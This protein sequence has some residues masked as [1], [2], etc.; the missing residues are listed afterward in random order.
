MSS[1][2]LS[3]KTTNTVSGSFSFKQVFKKEPIAWFALLITLIVGVLNGAWF[4]KL[5][6]GH[7]VAEIYTAR[8]TFGRCMDM[9]IVIVNNMDK[10]ALEIR[11]P[12]KVDPLAEQGAVV[13]FY[14][15]LKDLMVEPSEKTLAPRKTTFYV[16]YR[17]D[18]KE[19]VLRIPKLAPGE[20]IHLRYAES[21]KDDDLA[22]TRNDLVESKYDGFMDKPLVGPISYKDGCAKIKR[23]VKDNCAHK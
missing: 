23:I 4:W 15:T 3:K 12:I 19:F 10:P 13:P 18:P 22:K 5:F 17:F 8:D 21:A 2:K 1:K 9:E 7:L 11:A 20:R 14:G 16:P 6:E